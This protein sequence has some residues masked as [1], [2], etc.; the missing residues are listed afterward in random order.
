MQVFPLQDWSIFN[1][2]FAILCL[3]RFWLCKHHECLKWR[4][5][6]LQW[7]LGTFFSYLH[8]RERLNKTSIL[9]LRQ[10]THE[11][12]Q[13]TL[14]NDCMKPQDESCEM[15]CIDTVAHQP[16]GNCYTNNHTLLRKT[17][18]ALCNA[19]DTLYAIDTLTLW[20]SGDF[21][22]RDVALT[23]AGACPFLMARCQELRLGAAA[24]CEGSWFLWDIFLDGLESRISESKNVKTSVHH[25]QSSSERIPWLS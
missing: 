24:C 19:S 7:S 11:K 16:E 2:L 14:N 6:I 23:F 15:I 17:A 18:S 13:S 12:R 20:R 9:H 21:P 25:K 5:Y 8:T 4:Q 3:W 10:Y 1:P 22:S